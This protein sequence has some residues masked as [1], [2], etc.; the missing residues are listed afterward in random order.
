MSTRPVE[1][2]PWPMSQGPPLCNLTC[3]TLDSSG[4][5]QLLGWSS[6]ALQGPVALQSLE[7]YAVYPGQE[8]V[9]N[10]LTQTQGF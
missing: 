1:G 7:S 5:G 10:G 9:L 3:I 2:A 6:Y 8:Q 4:P